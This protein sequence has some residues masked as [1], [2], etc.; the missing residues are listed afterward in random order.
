MS[1]LAANLLLVLTAV[2]WGLAFVVQKVGSDHI[3]S[4]T[5][6]AARLFLGALVVLPFALI[7]WRRK[8]EPLRREDWGMMVTTGLVLC[9][10]SVTQQF[11]VEETSVA[12]AGFLTGLNVPMVPLIELL[13]LRKKP[14]PIIWPAAGLS[15][16][17]TY[18]MSGSG[19]LS[20]GKGDAWIVLSS[21]FWA[22]HI[23]LIGRTSSRTGLPTLLAVVQYLISAVLCAAWALAFEPPIMPGLQAA[24]RE[25]LFIGVMEVGLAYTLQ[26]IAQRYSNAADAA[27]ILSGE[28][29]FAALGGM[30]FLGERMSLLQAIGAAAIL[31][32]MLAV[33]LGPM[34]TSPSRAGIPVMRGGAAQPSRDV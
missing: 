20:F 23:I 28:M 30:L 12:N 7:H 6:I 16:V 8:R 26:T 14:H 22:V 33:Q 25:I 17:G 9:A 34:W 5:F 19:D 18:L 15:L 24:W 32:G 13:I 1:R 21:L 10:A 4:A 11:G 3:S 27:V 2:V 31:C 29:L